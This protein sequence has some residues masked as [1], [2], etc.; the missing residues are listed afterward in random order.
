M[1]N[2]SSIKVDY[3]GALA[4]FICL[5]HCL[6]TPFIFVAKACTH[7]CCQEAPLWWKIIDYVFLLISFIAIYYATKNSTKKMVKNALWLFWGVLFFIIL[8]ESIQL[9]KLPNE[10]IYIPAFFIIVLH[11]Y[12]QKYCKCNNETCC[13]NN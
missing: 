2:T 13:A 1:Q 7:T 8:N 10:T 4:G 12:N 9:V 5:I 11:I 3:F 6:A